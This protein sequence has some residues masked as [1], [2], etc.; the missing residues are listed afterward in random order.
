[1]TAPAL[2]QAPYLDQ[3]H[4]AL[5]N[6]DSVPASMTACIQKI[7]DASARFGEIW[8]DLSQDQ[9]QASVGAMLRE[10][11]LGFDHAAFGQ[12]IASLT[13]PTSSALFLPIGQNRA[14]FASLCLDLALLEAWHWAK[15]RHLLTATAPDTPAGLFILGLGKLGG[16]D[17]NF[18]SDV[19][20]IAFYD[21]EHFPFTT[22]PAEVKQRAKFSRAWADTV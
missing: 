4:S 20:V 18:S 22:T 14:D 13:D 5:T 9:V 19:D 8:A 6:S 21:K 11:K 16:R 3:C 17:L 1:M 2:L 15:K 12:E 10:A 7:E